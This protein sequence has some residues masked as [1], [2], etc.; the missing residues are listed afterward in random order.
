MTCV[1]FTFFVCCVC[2]ESLDSLLVFLWMHLSV[3]DDG[4]GT[5]PDSCAACWWLALR[6]EGDQPG[7]SACFCKWD[8]PYTDNVCAELLDSLLALPSAR[9][10]AFF[11]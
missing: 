8:D 4:P 5:T 11:V 7:P 2:A 6:L 3:P 9:R 10:S 1:S